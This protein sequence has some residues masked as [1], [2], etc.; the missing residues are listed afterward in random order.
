MKA[1]TKAHFAVLGTNLFFA[2]NYS[3]VKH[4][5]PSLLSPYA[6]NLLRVGISV[7]LFWLFWVWANTVPGQQRIAPGIHKKDFGLFFLCALTGVGLNQTFFM[8]GLT[9]TTPIHASLLILCTPLLITLLAFWIL[10][11]KITVLKMVGLA[12]GVGGSVTLILTKENTV[13]G[14]D[15]LTGDLLIMLNA[16]FYGFYFILVKPLMIK[17]SPVHV[18]RWIFTIGFFL[19]LPFGWQPMKEIHWQQFEWSH[20]SS[21]AFIVMAGTFLAYLFN[22]YGILH[23]G[24]GMTGSYIYTQPIFAAIIATLF[25]HETLSLQKIIAGTLIFGGVFLVS[26]KSPP[27]I[28]E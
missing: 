21:L 8:K 3:M 13:H 15:Y 5:S 7:A 16:I 19:L 27:V 20:I 24:A 4:I 26:R 23:L 12:L 25:L 2:S 11:E 9:L 1:T 10:K 17:Y 18:I 14:S 6:L 22:V 28:Q